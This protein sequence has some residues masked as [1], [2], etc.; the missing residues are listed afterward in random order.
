[1]RIARIRIAHMIAGAILMLLAGSLPVQ[2]A[3]TA[4][5]DRDA[6]AWK[7]WVIASGKQFRVPPPP[8]RGAT[9]KEAVEV[10]KLAATRDQ[11][12]LDKIAY[13]D[14]GAPSYRWSEL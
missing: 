8:D 9:K 7:T 2:A 10:G 3:D 1:M 14:T 13:W 5:S 12:A 11:D 6:G 4:A